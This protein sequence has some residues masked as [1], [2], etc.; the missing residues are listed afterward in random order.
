VCA[1]HCF[2]EVVK[3][4]LFSQLC[5]SDHFWHFV[6]AA[7]VKLNSLSSSKFVLAAHY[8][9]SITSQLAKNV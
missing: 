5:E 3:V 7:T 9:V 8:D 4:K 6:V 2:V 1:V